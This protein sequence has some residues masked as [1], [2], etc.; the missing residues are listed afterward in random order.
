MIIVDFDTTFS[1][2]LFNR[3]IQNISKLMK[4]KEKEK[5]FIDIIE[6][7]LQPILIKLDHHK[8]ILYK[9]YTILENPAEN[10]KNLIENNVEFSEVF[11]INLLKQLIIVLK[12]AKTQNI[13]HSEIKPE[14][15]FIYNNLEVPE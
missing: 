1:L 4:L 12:A 13:A 14:N 9:I 15:I 3:K 11:L 10:T 5:Q 8:K 6:F 7:Y 2:D